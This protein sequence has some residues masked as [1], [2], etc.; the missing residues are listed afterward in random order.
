MR[1]GMSYSS[2]IAISA[3]ALSVFATL[4]ALAEPN[5]PEEVDFVLH[6]PAGEA[7]DFPI[8]IHLTGKTKTIEQPGDRVLVIAPGQEIVV[9]NV[10]D[11]SKRVTLGITGAFHTTTEPNGTVRTKATGRNALFDP[12]AGFVLA[13]G[14]FSYA[15]DANGNLIEPL[16]GKGRVLDI[17]E[18]VAG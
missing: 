6:I 17:C 4:P 12:I 16:N 9:V 14:N 1:R 15:F 13:I 11:P 5:R 10:E 3:L 8:D 7:C 2:I 18:M